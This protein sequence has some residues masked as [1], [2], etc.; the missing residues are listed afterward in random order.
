MWKRKTSGF[1]TNDNHDDTDEDDKDDEDDDDDDEDTDNT[2]VNG[3][4]DDDN[5]VGYEDMKRSTWIKPTR[6][7]FNVSLN[8]LISSVTP[9]EIGNSGIVTLKQLV[10]LLFKV[11][12]Q[13]A[14]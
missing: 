13:R 1:K 9:I 11:Y 7:P 5:D 4:D 3:D 14:I 8:W 6:L 2:D 10:K 12:R